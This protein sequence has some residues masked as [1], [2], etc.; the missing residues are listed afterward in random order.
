MVGSES[1]ET[2]FGFSVNKKDWVTSLSHMQLRDISGQPATVFVNAER[3]RIHMIATDTDIIIAERI[4]GSV[5]GDGVAAMPTDILYDLSKKMGEQISVRRDQPGSIVLQSKNAVCRVIEVMNS[6]APHI[7]QHAYEADFTISAPSMKQALDLCRFAMSQDE[8]RHSFHGLFIECIDNVLHFVA[9]DGHRMSWLQLRSDAI[10]SLEGVVVPYRTV[11]ELVRIIETEDGVLNMSIS[12]SKIRVS[13][14]SFELSSRLVAAQFP[15][16]RQFVASD[17]SSTYK[18][19][20]QALLGALDLI[21]AV[22]RDKAKAIK[23]AIKEQVLTLSATSEAGHV[24]SDDLRVEVLSDRSKNCEMGVN[25][26]YLIDVLQA[27]KGKDVVLGFSSPFAP[28]VIRQDG[29]LEFV[30]VVMP[31]RLLNS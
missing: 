27:L 21:T 30:H 6:D 8:S 12:R 1:S 31:M 16:Y 29:G 22:H 15:Q 14:A 28:I 9:T 10:A 23:L 19:N 25:A 26:K 18:V 4:K 13:G 17:T 3:D 11:N 24:A 5:Q 7:A 2:Q 20:A